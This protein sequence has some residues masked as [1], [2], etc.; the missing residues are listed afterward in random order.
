MLSIKDGE[1]II[2]GGLLQEEDRKTRTTIP[3][4]G[5]LPLIG[6]LISSFKTQRVTTE[7]ILT[8][9]PHIVQNMTPPALS[10]Q[11]F[12]SGTESTY[13]TGPMFS[14]PAQKVSA[15]LGSAYGEGAAVAGSAAKGAGDTASG[16]SL[17]QLAVPDP[18]LAIRPDESAVKFGKE[19]KLSI[20]DGRLSASGQNLF[21]LEYDPKIL[22]FKRLG[23]AELVSSSGISPEDQ[24]AAVGT[25]A[26][27]LARPAQRAPRSVSVVFVAKAL[28]VSP[29]RVELVGS[30]GD[31][32]P[33]S[34]EIG[35]GVVRVR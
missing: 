15:P 18:V 14:I 7:V 2:L 29:I 16:R 31:S 33:A 26:F 25:V 34:S 17:A 3:W 9:T 28:G 23:E 30:D 21:K 6:D 11:T 5:D 4:I 13:A 24:G 32:R 35:T 19:I 20:V 22:Q 8:I 27:R 1:T 10:A 12:W